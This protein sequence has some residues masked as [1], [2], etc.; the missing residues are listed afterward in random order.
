MR[1]D[2]SSKCLAFVRT[3]SKARFLRSSTAAL[4][5]LSVAPSASALQSLREPTLYG[6]TD[7]GE[8]ITINRSTGSGTVLW[9]LPSQYFGFDSLVFDGAHF[10]ASYGAFAGGGSIVQ[11][12]VQPSSDV[13]LGPTLIGAGPSVAYSIEDMAVAPNGKVFVAYN[14]TTPSP[15]SPAN[16]IGILHIG[17]TGCSI[18]FVTTP[19]N[20]SFHD[21]DAIAFDG[22]GNLWIT[23]LQSPSLLGQVS[24]PSGIVSHVSSLAS[25]LT[26]L[27]PSGRVRAQAFNGTNSSIDFGPSNLIT[28]T[29]SGAETVVGPVGISHTVVGL[30]LVPRLAS[31]F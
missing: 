22:L 12:D 14:D 19:S 21:I 4:L 26:G 24:L 23:N 28:V 27:A 31:R 18:T 6:I 17:A 1:M 29:D 10:Y 13:D 2:Q 8:F 16:K 9:E 5:V 25:R 7:P 15:P 3:A 30:V 11:F 20:P